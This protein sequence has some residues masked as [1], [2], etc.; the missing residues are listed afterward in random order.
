MATN[1][2]SEDE[3]DEKKEKKKEKRGRERRGEKEVCMRERKRLGM[4]DKD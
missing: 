4:L 1:L 3:R 2:H